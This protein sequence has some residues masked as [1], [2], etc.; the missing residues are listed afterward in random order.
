[1]IKFIQEALKRYRSLRTLTKNEEGA[2]YDQ[3]Y[4]RKRQRQSSIIKAFCITF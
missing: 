1:M 4:I 3:N 2:S